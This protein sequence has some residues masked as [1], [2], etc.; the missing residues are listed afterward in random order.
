MF[1]APGFRGQD[2]QVHADDWVKVEGT[3]QHASKVKSAGSECVMI[4]QCSD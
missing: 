3:F 2:S 1:H 4:L